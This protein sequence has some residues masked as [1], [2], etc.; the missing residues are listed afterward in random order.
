V[1]RQAVNRTYQ[2][3]V[4]NTKGECHNAALEN[5]NTAGCVRGCGDS[6]TIRYKRMRAPRAESVFAAYYHIE[7]CWVGMGLVHILISLSSMWQ[8]TQS[9]DS[10]TEVH[11][12]GPLYGSAANP[13]LSHI[14]AKRS[15]ERF[16]S[17]PLRSSRSHQVNH[18]CADQTPELANGNH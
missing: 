1:N 9:R 8:E 4:P 7:N 18:Q 13:L 16:S 2:L 14:L 5:G 10:S 3:T 12:A 11:S 15:F 17:Q 6:N